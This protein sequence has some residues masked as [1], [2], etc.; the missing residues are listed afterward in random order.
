M[1]PKFS[2]P[3]SPI[4]QPVGIEAETEEITSCDGNGGFRNRAIQDYLFIFKELISLVELVKAVKVDRVIWKKMISEVTMI[5]PLS[6][7]GQH[8]QSQ[9]DF[10]LL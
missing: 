10:F 7:L 5:I 9:F 4:E 2:H 6:F 1:P 8:N 3:S